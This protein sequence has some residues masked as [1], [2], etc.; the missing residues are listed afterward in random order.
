MWKPGDRISHRHNPELGPGRI[1][2]VEGR[3]LLVEFPRAGTSLRLAAQSDAIVRAEIAVGMRVV[4]GDGRAP[5]TV[6]AIHEDGSCLLSDG[7]IVPDEAVWPVETSARLVDRLARGDVDPVDA[8][9]LRLEATRLRALR[10]ARGLGSFLGG[11]IRL[12]PH[13]L[14][15]AEKATKTDPVRWLLADEVGLGKTVEA[16]LILNHLV[17]T[18][19]AERI[20]VVA[21]ATLTI[22]WLG[23]LWRKFHHV[24][25]LLDEKRLADVAR[26]YGAGTNPFE[27]HRKVVISLETL[28]AE[29]RLVEEAA[30][31]HLDLLIVDEA[32][33]LRRPPGHP[34]EPPYR[35]VAPLAAASRH[36]L[37][38]TATP[39]EDDA[40]GFFRLLQLLRPEEFPEEAS[41]EARLAR[42]EKLPPCTSSTRRADVGRLLPPRVA[43]PVELA[44]ELGWRA[45]D[46]LVESVRAMPA[47]NAALERTKAERLRRA[48]SSPA[49][50]AAVLRPDERDLRAIAREADEKDPRLRWLA[51]SA[52]RFKEAGDKTLVFVA[53]RETL[54]AVRSGLSRLAQIR[55]GVFHEELSPVQRDLEAA[56]FRR[57][58]GPSILVSTECGGEGRNFEFCT[59]LVLYDL[60]VDPGSVEQRIGRLDRIGRTMPVEIVYFRPPGG[61]L[62]EVASVY[63]RLGVFSAPLGGLDR[64]LARLETALVGRAAGGKEAVS[65]GELDRILSEIG[66]ARGRVLAALYR[67]LHRD[68]YE[69]AL[70]ASIL[71]RIPA[72][73]D[74]MTEEVV[75]AAAEQLGFRVEPQR[76]RATYSIEFGSTAL[77][78]RLPG[79]R[80]GSSFVGT[81]DRE[82]AVAR[83]QLDY[84]SSGHPLVEGI[85]AYL[86]ESP[87]GRVC[88]LE[89][90]GEEEGFGLVAL[91]RTG[92]SVRAFAVDAEGRERRDWAELLER[93]PFRTRRVRPESWCRQPGWSRLI[94]RLADLLPR[95]IEPDSLAALRVRRPGR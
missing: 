24:F 88:L 94:R 41:F 83:E 44:D 5:A 80:A 37:L 2:S 11:R 91:Y 53:Y 66:E 59:R 10:E 74:A 85:L 93:R 87:R 72:D 90:S 84:F 89:V 36:A 54:E 38:L 86:D 65:D 13:Q 45:W 51:E 16:C 30:C 63:E 4:A 92:G 34:G 69:P 9:A 23:E 15:V 43:R 6:E 1:V 18:G 25:V 57:P 42:G 39:L 32:H 81:F 46:R 64:E 47:S 33:R 75:L 27:V 14:Y 20:V 71:E 67:E 26:D 76:G 31:S 62:R 35:A 48:L 58:E 8:F 60:P 22:Q 21:P 40:H 56:E 28:V 50:L 52:R 70:A 3:T 77:V 78:D 29:P 12:F 7:R 68:P 95:E 61:F 17:H 19:R 49:A 79:V 82:E 55:C 73:L